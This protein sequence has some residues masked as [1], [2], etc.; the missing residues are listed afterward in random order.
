MPFIIA[1]PEPKRFT[2]SWKPKKGGLKL[3]AKIAKMLMDH[4]VTDNDGETVGKVVASRKVKDENYIIYTVQVADKMLLERA[5]E[6]IGRMENNAV[7]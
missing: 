6:G 2:V 3:T 1:P 5:M 7:R 4:N